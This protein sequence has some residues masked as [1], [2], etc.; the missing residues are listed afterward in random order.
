[1]PPSGSSGTDWLASAK[2][3]LDAPAES[4]VLGFGDIGRGL[5]TI[6]SESEPQFAVGIFGGW[7]TGKTTLMTAIKNALP[8]DRLVV[9]D[10]NAWRF[11]REPQL[12]IPLLDTIRAALV[13]WG[14]L[15]DQPTGEKVR[16]IAS[17]IGRVVRALA[18]GLSGEAGLPGAA[19]VSYDLGKAMEVLS[20]EVT[21]EEAQSLYHAAFRELTEAFN[22][23]VATSLNRVVVFVDDLDRCLPGNAIEV[24]ESIKLFFDF[25]G[26]VFVVG[27][28]DSLVMRAVRAKFS[29]QDDPSAVMQAGAT[30][31]S[32]VATNQRLAREYLKKIF[33]L[34]YSLPA[35]LPQQLDDL[36]RS[37]Y[38][39]AGLDAAQLND[40]QLR[41]RPYLGYIA[42]ERRVNPR[43]VKRFVNAYTLQ[44]L[45]RPSLDPDTVL[46]LQTLVFRDEWAGI[47]DAIL[48]DSDMFV[49]TLRR[50][51]D[52]E[53]EEAAFGDLAPGLRPLPSSL[54][55]YLR[56]R[57]AEPLLGHESL[58][59]Y[60]SSLQSTSGAGSWI[61]EAY[62]QIG[63]L[64]R[65]TQEALS[66][67]PTSA[68]V[69]SISTSA[70]AIVTEISAMMSS[71][72]LPEDS[73]RLG[74]ILEEIRG[75]AA[76]AG[77]LADRRQLTNNEA[78]H[79]CL[80]RLER[81]TG[82]L[83]K[84]LKFVRDFAILQ[85]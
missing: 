83:R 7:G 44:T 32:A 55:S 77:E 51:R 72:V 78:L 50:Y 9:V 29:Y 54:A 28:D 4:P 36:L 34:S 5:A 8:S 40:F 25:P 22:G 68:G 20:S 84:E 57:L 71:S 53:A 33:Q 70:V 43:Q 73:Q 82:L 38:E 85:P 41:V 14:T 13:R 2:I 24:L 15:R 27:L 26:F 21:A 16:S 42:V 75:A 37:M 66:G 69:D 65:L 3:L 35:M 58:D 63:H 74:L 64:R 45:V 10:F 19:K 67:T 17:K 56:S 59:P 12:L 47:Y 80:D 1:M 52:D 18:S 81:A 23:L 60:I 39:Q 49:E 6:I 11:E 31:P 30:E 79:S 62:K 76:D 48:T 46:A 61:L